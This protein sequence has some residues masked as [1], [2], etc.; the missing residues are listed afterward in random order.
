MDLT[1]LQI[2]TFKKHLEISLYVLTFIRY[3]EVTRLIHNK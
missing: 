3:K 1:N 2:Q